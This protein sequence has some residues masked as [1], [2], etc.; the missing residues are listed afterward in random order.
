MMSGTSMDGVDVALIETDGIDITGFG[1]AESHPYSDADRSVLQA[2]LGHWPGTAEAA[3][4]AEVIERTHVAALSGLPEVALVGVHGQTLAHD[5][6]TR[7]THQV[8]DGGRIAEASGRSVV[9]DFRSAD[10][11]LGGQ[12]APLAPFYHWALARA[13]GADRPVVMLNLGGVGNLSWVDPRTDAPETPGACIAFDTGPANAPLDDLMQTR[14]GLRFD[15]D[16][17]LAATGV[18]DGAIVADFLDLPYFS[19]PPPKS[20]DRNAFHDVLKAVSSHSDADAAG[21]IAACVAGSVAAGLTHLPERPRDILV[22]GGGR[23]NR[24]IMEM[25]EVATGCSARPVEAV[26]LDGDAL[27]AQAFAYLAVRVKRGLPTSAPGTTGVAA[28]V[29]GGR[30]S[31]PSR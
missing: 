7:R 24:A 17:A 3:A 21:T 16:G 31:R 19:L 8:G 11:A 26:G 18:V 5:P 2:A 14:R 29:G 20:L 30:L 28:A 22:T 23:A 9:W 10:L 15:Q 4:A 25:L 13:M 6:D 12:G 1:P 27:E